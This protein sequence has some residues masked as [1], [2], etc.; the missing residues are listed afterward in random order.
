MIENQGEIG[1]EWILEVKKEALYKTDSVCKSWK[2]F[3]IG[4]GIQQGCTLLKRL[5]N[6]YDE[7]MI[8]E[9][10]LVMKHGV[11]VEGQWFRLVS[12]AYR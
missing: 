11:K 1:M 3:M 4:R 10:Q 5:H 9:A 8:R 6:L 7:A 2:Q 12:F